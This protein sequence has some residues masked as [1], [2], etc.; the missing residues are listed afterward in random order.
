MTYEVKYFEAEGRVT[1]DMFETYKK[2][3]A[4]LLDT[5]EGLITLN[6]KD[7][8]D[9]I[10]GSGKEYIYVSDLL[11]QKPFDQVSWWNDFCDWLTGKA[12][13]VVDAVVS[14]LRILTKIAVEVVGRDNAVKVL[15][16]SKDS[17]GIYHA[18]FDCW[19][20]FC[21]YTDFYDFVFSIGSKMDST[22]NT[23]Y[24][25]DSDGLDDYVLWGWKG[26]YW[27]LGY[28]GEMGIYKRLGDS[29]IWYVDKNL[30]ID[31]TLKVDYRNSTTSTDWY[32]IID[33]E[34]KKAEGYEDK[35]WWITG[36]NPKYANESL[37]DK[38]MLRASYTVRFETKGYSEDL[39]RALTDNFYKTYI[40]NSTN[41][42]YNRS[43]GEFSYT[44]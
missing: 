6:T 14:C 24:D 21:G 30:A 40:K 10:F 28:G 1:L 42:K 2:T 5:I 33:W 37:K 32:T 23:F 38:S 4:P 44:L 26:D 8:P 15:N 31:M 43:T 41:W 19:Q 3:K 34:P 25:E 35:Q 20:R 18:D 27:E 39:N 13:D 17:N 9:V 7:E 36:F 16:M 11:T 12:K 22:K 29:E